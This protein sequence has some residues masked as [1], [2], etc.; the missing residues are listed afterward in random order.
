MWK[1]TDE[2]GEKKE[3]KKKKRKLFK[4]KWKKSFTKE[5][6]GGNINEHSAESEWEDIENWTETRQNNLDFR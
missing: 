6:E 3:R 5:G 2:K 4:K 1:N